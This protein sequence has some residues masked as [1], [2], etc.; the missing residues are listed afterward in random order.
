MAHHSLSEDERMKDDKYMNFMRTYLG[1]QVKARFAIH[2]VMGAKPELKGQLLTRFNQLTDEAIAKKII[3]IQDKQK[4]KQA[5]L[6]ENTTVN[7]NKPDPASIA[8][9]LYPK[10]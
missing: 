6:R 3:T 8:L 10:S 2:G 1:F 4:F 5:I 7:T 9:T